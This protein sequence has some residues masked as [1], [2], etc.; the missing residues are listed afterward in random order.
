VTSVTS[1]LRRNGITGAEFIIPC[2]AIVLGALLPNQLNFLMLVATMA[3]FVL[4][5]DLI[6][7]Y[8]GLATLGHAAFFGVGAYSAGL[9]SISVTSEPI[10]GLVVGAL[11]AGILAAIS[12]LMILRAHGLTL[13]MMTVAF[14]QIIFE[15]ANKA[16]SITGGD[17]GLYGIMMSPIFGIFEFD[18]YGRTG[19]AYSVVVLTLVFV[20]LRV[21]T[22]SPFGLSLVGIREDRSRMSAMGTNVF[23]HLLASYTISGAIAGVAGAVTAQTVQVIGLNSLSFSLSAEALVMLVLGGTGKLWGAL[24]GTA[25]FMMVHHSVAAAD[26]FRWMLVIG[27]MLVAVVLFLPGGLVNAWRPLADR[28]RARG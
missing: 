24:V 6:V 25:I 4:S 20:G 27:G 28:V 13:L 7:G 11:A 9:W 5:L 10:S 17:D 18:F 26:P 1:S 14:A 8:T 22:T 16:R 12:G 19:Y 2:I 15:I 21:L 23:K 3:I